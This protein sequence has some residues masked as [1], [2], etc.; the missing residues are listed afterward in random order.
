M[1]SIYKRQ[2]GGPRWG[3]Q[4]GVGG[5]VEVV[6]ALAG[7]GSQGGWPASLGGLCL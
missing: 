3:T 2:L 7:T 5:G 6:Q 4:S 1:T